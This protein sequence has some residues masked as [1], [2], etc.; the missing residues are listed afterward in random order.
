[1][2]IINLNF[3]I[4]IIIIK[5]LNYQEILKLIMSNKI[6]YNFLDNYVEK[7]LIEKIKQHFINLQFFDFEIKELFILN[8]IYNEFKFKKGT[9]IPDFLIFIQ[10]L[11]ECVVFEK[12]L[13]NCFFNKN[14]KSVWNGIKSGDL[15]CLITFASVYQLKIITN[16]L[17]I[18]IEIIFMNITSISKKNDKEYKLF[19]IKYLLHQYFYRFSEYTTDLINKIVKYTIQN[20]KFNENFILSFIIE[21]QKYFNYEL[22]IKYFLNI[23]EYKNE[24]SYIEF[25]NKLKV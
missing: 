7:I 22:K 17:K 23:A 13:S 3:D 18:P 4:F 10:D 2:K 24:K 6:F 12:L 16:H 19:L 15:C 1:M 5:K 9:D 25:F 21:S 14:I 8:K 11:D 20:Y